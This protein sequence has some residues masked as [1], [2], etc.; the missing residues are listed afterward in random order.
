MIGDMKNVKNVGHLKHY[1]DVDDVRYVNSITD[2]IMINQ[3]TNKVS[4]IKFKPDVC[5]TKIELQ[6]G[7]YEIEVR[8]G[9][10]Y[11]VKAKPTYPKT[12]EECC[13]V[14]GIDVSRKFTYED[15]PFYEN[16]SFYEN[17]ILKM[18][19]ALRK[20][21]ICRDAYWKLAGEQ[22]GL[23]K[24]WKP[25][26]DESED[27]YTIHTFNGEIRLSGTAHRNAI[28]VFP[29]EEMR[30]TFDVNFEN[31]IEQCKELL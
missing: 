20:L 14:S 19:E 16:C 21:I 3:I 22:M 23:G 15:M 7:D 30:D 9:K 4:V 13:K 18:F 10:T 5:D 17:D 28:L 25:V 31:L 11:A 6:L 12:Y 27:L 1:K 2:D 26:W 24:P 8:D 29:T